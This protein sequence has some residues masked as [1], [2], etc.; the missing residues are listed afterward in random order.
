M[1]RLLDKIDIILLAKLLPSKFFGE[2]ITLWNKNFKHRY[3]E[4]FGMHKN[5]K[6]R[7][8]HRLYFPVKN[9]KFIDN[10][11]LPDYIS[12]FN[13]FLQGVTDRQIVE[14]FN[15]IFYTLNIKYSIHTQVIEDYVKEEFNMNNKEL[16][17][18]KLH[19]SE[20][21]LD[22]LKSFNAIKREDLN[23]GYLI[24][25]KN[26]KIKIIKFMQKIKYL[27][28]KAPNINK[29]FL[30]ALN[31]S[32]DKGIEDY[33]NYSM[34]LVDKK[35]KDQDYE[36]VISR[37]P[38]DIARMST[39]R[40]WRSCMKLPTHEDPEC[41]EYYHY[42]KKDIEKGTL[43]CYFIRKEDHSIKNP[44]GR[45][46]IKPY[47]YAELGN[48]NKTN[49]FKIFYSKNRKEI[50]LCGEDIVNVINFLSYIYKQYPKISEKIEEK[51]EL[52][53]IMYK[54]G[55]F[56]YSSSI[57][58][59]NKKIN[60][61]ILIPSISA[62]YFFSIL[63]LNSL[64][65]NIYNLKD[66]IKY[67]YKDENKNFD[68]NDKIEVDEA[69]K[70]ITSLH[71][72]LL[73]IIYKIENITNS[74]NKEFDEYTKNAKDKKPLMVV[75]KTHYGQFPNEAVEVL[76]EWLTNEVNKGLS[77]IYIKDEDLYDDGSDSIINTSKMKKTI[78]EKGGWEG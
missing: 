41:G 67:Y 6:F 20:E 40:G 63:D 28:S 37:H 64:L 74:F 71:K 68:K 73:N 39:D 47:I 53:P 17:N 29:K 58:G 44:L 34:T 48:E 78:T 50:D 51:I 18:F 27:I 49:F 57:F 21:L 4:L 11:K 13:L 35:K 70:N 72:S 45:I 55:N 1:Y 30:E 59:S 25:N 62:H 76:E 23:A 3:D 24:N 46:N 5:N 32:L 9:V 54:Q 75:E 61:E 19:F 33:N 22:Y 52:P 43:V 16:Y 12:K 60:F 38:Y 56:I 31:D 42:I 7:Q 66:Y 36:I 69:N 15:F 77:G 14:F 26:Q 8:N 2:C 10:T 65:L